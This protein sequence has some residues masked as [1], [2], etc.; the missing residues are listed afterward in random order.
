[1]KNI[2]YYL[3]IPFL[4]FLAVYFGEKITDNKNMDIKMQ[5]VLITISVMAIIL[6]IFD[7]I[8]YFF[9]L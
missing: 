5:V 9:Y 7:S 1:M 6:I 4:T 3:L 2:L 8:F